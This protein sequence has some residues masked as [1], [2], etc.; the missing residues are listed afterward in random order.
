M[1]SRLKNLILYISLLALLLSCNNSES[2]LFTYQSKLRIIERQDHQKC[3]SQGLDYGDWDEIVTEMYWRCRYNLV[4]DRKINTSIT[5]ASIKNNAVIEKISEEIL[6][7][8]SR[9]KYSAL[10]KIDDDIELSDHKKCV[11]LGYNLGVLE[12]NDNYYRCRQNLIIA[13]I[14]PAPKVTNAFETAILPPDRAAEYLQIASDSRSKNQEV[15]TALEAMQQYPNCA[16][17]NIKTADF[18]KCAAAADKSRQCLASVHSLQIKKELQDKIYCQ[19]QAF[20]QF[21]DNYALAKDKSS[22]E[23]EK[24][25]LDIKKGKDKQLTEEANATLL[26]LEGNRSL[27]DNIGRFEGRDD[28]SQKAKEKLYSRVELLQLR[29]RFVLQCNKKMEDKLPEFADKT[30]GD[31]LNIAKNWADTD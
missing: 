14:P 2:Y 3:V 6:K 18:K 10:A 28:E 9:A 19:Q 26:Y 12:S 13:R 20:I 23:I 4:Q 16:L 25:K 21:P 15:N 5:P 24:L 31:C 27:T 11:S 1:F 7:N 30:S 8:L 22:N 29:E 17:L